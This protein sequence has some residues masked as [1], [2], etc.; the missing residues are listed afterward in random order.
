MA[1]F[2]KFDTVTELHASD[3]GAVYSARPSGGGREIKYAVKVFNPRSL[4]LDEQFW[5]TQA[6]Q[7]RARV[8]QR[9]ADAGHGHW[10]PIHEI[11]T[12]GAGPFYVTDFHPLSA[13]SLVAGKVDVSAGVLYAIIRSVVSGLSDLKALAGRPH[14]NLKASNVLISSRGNVAVAGAVLTDPA[15]PAEAAKVG[16]AGDL[17]AL[18]ELIYLLVMGRPF[19]GG[20]AWPAPPSRDWLK[21]GRRQGLQWRRLCNDL[22]NPDPTARLGSLE[23]VTKRLRRL[24]PKRPHPSRRMSIAAIVLLLLLAGGAAAVLGVRDAGA[25]REICAAEKKWAGALTRALTDPDRRLLFESDPDLRRVVAELDRADLRSFDCDGAN[26]AVSFHIRQYQQTQE[27]LAALRRAERGLSPLQWR[28]LADAA[29][30]QGYFEGRGWTQPAM[31]LAERIAAARPGSADVAGGVEGFLRALEAVN[32]DLEKAQAQ[33]RV[34][35]GSTRELDTKGDQILAAFADHLRRQGA[36]SLRLTD[37]GF[38]GLDALD[39]AADRARVLVAA[40]SRITP[41][42]YDEERFNEDIR[43]KIKLQEGPVQD[44]DIDLWL[45]TLETYAIQRDAIVSEVARLTAEAERAER[46]VEESKPGENALVA[47]KDRKRTVQDLL[48]SFQRQPFIQQDLR[49]PDGDF[50]RE[51][52]RVDA[53]IKSMR[54]LLREDYLGEWLEKLPELASS[55]KVLNERWE[56]HRQALLKN[57]EKFARNPELHVEAR[58]TTD[59]LWKV[60]PTLDKAFPRTPHKL[61][62]QGMGAFNQAARDKREQALRHLLGKHDPS[63]L[64]PDAEPVKTAAKAY[65]DWTENLIEL[66]RDFPLR[67]EILGVEERPDVKWRKKNAAFW[68]DPI[69]RELVR[70]HVERIERLQVVEHAPRPELLELAANSEVPEVA[71]HAWRL[72]GAQKTTP[73]WPT[74]PDELKV[75]A[76]VRARIHDLIWAQVND[77]TERTK[78]FEEMQRQGPVRWTRFAEAAGADEQMLASAAELREAMGVA[79][80]HLDTLTPTARFNFALLATRRLMADNANDQALRPLVARLEKAAAD[81]KEGQV[82]QQLLARLKRVHEKGPFAAQQLGDTFELHPFNSQVGV[83]MRRVKA[84]GL[85]PF[86]LGT[87]EVSVAQFA[88][89][90]DAS[91]AWD[92]VRSLVWFPQPGRPS[93]PRK[94]PRTWE[95]VTR[96]SPRMWPPELWLAPDADNFFPPAFRKGR[97]NKTVLSEAVGGNPSESHPLQYVPPEAA[98]Y[99]AALCECRLPTSAE[100]S[101][102]YE[103]F[104]KTVPPAQ[105]NLRDQA[106]E[107]YRNFA[108]SA[109][110]EGVNQPPDAGIFLP[111]KPIVARGAT[112]RGHAH[113]DGTLYFR[114][115]DAA[116]GGETFRHLVGNVAEFVHD[117]AEVFEAAPRRN[118][119][120]GAGQFLADRA[121]GLK[122]VGGSAL[123]PIELPATEPLPARPGGNG[124]ADVGIRLAF[125]APARSIAE[126][127][128]WVLAGQGYVRPEASAGKESVSANA[129]MTKSET[130]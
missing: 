62:I 94:G 102:A 8:Q 66:S 122:V 24:V 61:T 4:E 37:E 14:G 2:G 87:T 18:G 126:R 34:L 120:E 130:E 92:A 125:T 19:P 25:R 32:R 86:Y 79:D 40:H 39:A 10:A 21:L 50:H 28:R 29:Q 22:L 99:F 45:A 49:R 90:L 121:D 103:Q 6:F 26:S 12:S 70:P 110:A 15:P 112:A 84:P 20:N 51:I 3:R 30:L 54:G 74:A 69:V 97:F 98:V 56:Q 114:A 11:G 68:D 63:T 55:S 17:R 48:Q 91:G 123:S 64:T 117:D 107:A 111:P 7:E 57:K 77:E 53:E 105:W 52:E 75:E 80:T 59:R 100:W 89:I 88:S 41:R 42:T 1:T 116:P 13:A 113:D 33:W 65:R 44:G 58:D 16:E 129:G 71:L 76:D 5:E 104:E 35:Q 128:E 115:V 124:Y 82:P 81:L 118:T 127:L 38:K 23:A 83:P 119:P 78:A 27:R 46:E 31:Y 72:L 108:T 101:A 67:T 43:E 60:L 96:P 109:E 106:W 73:P 9:V 93:D 85:R 47:L 36:R 95:W